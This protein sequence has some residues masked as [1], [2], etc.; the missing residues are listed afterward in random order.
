MYGEE[1]IIYAT[2]AGKN[3]YPQVS[4]LN[5]WK[6]QTKSY[7]L[8]DLD[9]DSLITDVLLIGQGNRFVILSK[10]ESSSRF[11]IFNLDESTPY[12]N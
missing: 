12:Y 6:S 3:V 11:I 7:K 8:F 4:V 10:E 2:K 5:V 9:V 1:F